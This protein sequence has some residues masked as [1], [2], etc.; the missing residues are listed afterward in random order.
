MNSFVQFA[1]RQVIHLFVWTTLKGKS[2]PPNGVAAIGSGSLNMAVA[3]AN[4]TANII[5][6][7]YTNTSRDDIGIRTR[8]HNCFM[9]Y[10][11]DVNNQ[12][13]DAVKYMSDGVAKSVKTCVSTALKRV[14]SC[15][16]ELKR[17]L[18]GLLLN[19]VNSFKD[20]C[21]VVLAICNKAPY[22]KWTRIAN[23]IND[24]VF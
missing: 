23:V 10:S 15:E 3:Q 2:L 24:V 22:L 21:S 9:I 20:I 1:L 18:S 6:R 4:K 5:W 16:K 13:N 7:R 17:E 12:L 19:A 14:T 11:V 8:Y